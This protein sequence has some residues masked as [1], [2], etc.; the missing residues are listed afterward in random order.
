MGTGFLSEFVRN[1]LR[2]AA[3]APSS[4]ALARAML[5]RVDLAAVRSIVEY[6]PGTGVF[7]R[8]T[9]DAL[10]AAG[11]TTARYLAL[12]LNPRMAD[13]LRLTLPRVDVRCANALDVD[14]ELGP[15]AGGV[16]LIISGL[17]WP[18]IPVGPR[19]E[20]LRKTR[21]MLRRGGRFHTFG[22]HIGLC[23]VGA[24]QFR[25]CVR[26]LFDNV[27]IS[28]VVWA[29]VPPAFVYRCVA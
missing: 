6:G 17:G 20:I 21:A 19:T 3:I 9:L 27:N 16:D 10:D 22:Y 23:M 15:G 26:D 11:N 2:T 24:W 1:P 12:E 13:D 5:D 29:N 7:T 25:A 14:R 8:T 4:K 18:S 28:P